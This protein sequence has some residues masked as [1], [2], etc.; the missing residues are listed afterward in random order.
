MNN[1]AL[2]TVSGIGFGAVMLACL[3]L[4]KF[5]FLVLIMFMM[6]VMMAEFYRMTMGESYRLQRVMAMASGCILCLMVFIH[7]AFGVPARFIALSIIP[8]IVLMVCTLYIKDR[9]GYG[10]FAFLF[11]GILYLAVPCSLSSFVAFHSGEFNTLLMLE[12]FIL[13][14]CSDIG[15]YAFGCALGQKHGK[16]LFPEISPK[17]SWIGFWGGLFLAILASCI[18]HWTGLFD[19]SIVH[20]IILAILMNVAGVFGDLF[21][22]QWKRYCGI[23]DSGNI[24][25]GHGG[26]L[27]RFDSALFAIPVGAVYMALTNLL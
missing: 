1:L 4:D 22:S 7:C 10:K 17:K 21:E 5:L 11:T 15:A 20:C 18:M 19:F 6:T 25:P 3:L 13:I 27:D 8:V 9:S 23:K 16:K 2:R 24:I 14:W 26:M 12:F